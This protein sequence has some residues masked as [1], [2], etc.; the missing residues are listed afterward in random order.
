MK[1]L[2]NID[3]NKNQTLNRVVQVLA[4]APGSPTA[5]QEYYNSTSNYHAIY[6]G[7][8]WVPTDASK[9]SGAIPMTAL[10]V[11]PTARANHSGTQLASTISNLA[12]TVQAYVLSSFA[13][14]TANIPMG[15]YT[16]TGLATPTTAGQ[17]AEY[18]WVQ[19]QVQASAAGLSV[20][21][22]VQAVKLVASLAA[23]PS[24]LTAYDGYTPIAGDRILV[25]DSSLTANI[26]NG[27]WV[28]A[29]GSWT[30]SADMA[31][32][33]YTPADFVFVVN[34]T[35][36]GTSQFKVTTTAAITVGTTAVAWAQFGGGTTYTATNGVQL[37]GSVMSVLLATN[38]GLSTSGSGITVALQTT[39]G[40]VLGASGL[41]VSLATGSGL[42]GPALTLTSGLSVDTSVVARKFSAT[43]GDGSTTA[44]VVTHSLGTQNIVVSVRDASTNVAYIT[45]WTATSTTTATINFATAPTTNSLIV[46]I[47]A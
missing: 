38:S 2:N 10:T 43:I 1:F 9:L 30:R 13:A 37:V 20:K 42:S 22:P 47:L 44:I 11:D 8:A 24:G 27:I 32:G 7:S 28:A 4:S 31:Q 29:A 35:T 46:T 6:N 12:A 16:L 45:D 34:G 17:A 26:Y 40:L 19:A 14:P 33:Y 39:P 15:G 23:A 21:A 25:L 3:L 5:G 41:A 36:Y 18:S